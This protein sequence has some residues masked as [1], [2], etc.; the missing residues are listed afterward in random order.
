LRITRSEIIHGSTGLAKT[1]RRVVYIWLTGIKEDHDKLDDENMLRWAEVVAC[2]R[3][4]VAPQRG[5]G[6]DKGGRALPPF[7]F[8]AA[9]YMESSYALGDALLGRRKWSDPEVLEQRDILLGND[10]DAAL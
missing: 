10:D 9:V 7:R 1:R 3:D 4:L 5:G 2:H 8:P 6:G